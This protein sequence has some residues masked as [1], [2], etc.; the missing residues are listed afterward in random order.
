M[1]A[2]S[3][4]YTE[5]N[6]GKPVGIAVLG[7]GTVGTEV[8]RLLAENSE[9]FRQRVGGPLELRGVAVDDTSKPRRG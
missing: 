5:N 6:A 8:I 1:V 4:T 3:P 7:M 2:N 9:D